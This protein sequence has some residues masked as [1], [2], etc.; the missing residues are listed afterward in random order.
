[1][2][3]APIELSGVAY[4]SNP[5]LTLQDV[6][7]NSIGVRFGSLADMSERHTDVRITLKIGPV[8]VREFCKRICKRTAQHGMSQGNTGRDQRVGN[9]KLE[10]MLSH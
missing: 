8:V 9:S 3:P 6:A 5:S 10:H 4:G 1:M 2:P 7:P